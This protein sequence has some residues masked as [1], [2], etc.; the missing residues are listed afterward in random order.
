MTKRARLCRLFGL[1]AAACAALAL[2][3][4]LRAA[5]PG[6]GDPDAL[7]RDRE[8]L[9]LAA[10]A[11]KIWAA[12]LETNPADYDAACKLARAEHWIGERLARD[13]TRHFKAGMAAARQAIAAGPERADGYFWLGA[14]LG[15]HAGAGGILAALRYLKP[16]RQAFETS[17]RIDPRFNKGT[18]WCLLGKYYEAVP[19]LFGGSKTK[20]EAML[21]RCLAV[22]PDSILG[23]TTSRRPARPQEG[24]RSRLPPRSRRPSIRTSDRKPAC[25]SARRRD[26]CRSS[27][28]LLTAPRLQGVGPS[29]RAHRLSRDSCGLSHS[30]WRLPGPCPTGGTSWPPAPASH[31]RRSH[32]KGMLAPGYF[33]IRRVADLFDPASRRR[34][35]GGGAARPRCRG[36]GGAAHDRDVE[37]RGLRFPAPRRRRARRVRARPLSVDMMFQVS[38]ARPSAGPSRAP[39]RGPAPQAGQ[40]RPQRRGGPIDGAAAPVFWQAGEYAAVLEYCAADVMGTLAL[41]VACQQSRRLA[42]LSRSGRPNEIALRR[43]W[44]TVEQCLAL[45]LPDTSWMTQPLSRDSV[46]GWT[47]PS[48]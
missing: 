48:R 37:R 45:P 20:A 11:A 13:R 30:T 25:G 12:R 7:F 23:T 6:S 10:Q 1:T 14:N 33:S 4:A 31:A 16:T 36:G 32:P 34:D 18:A 35:T 21:R 9:G 39:R 43:G 29:E 24:R 44:L 22:D 17:V 38:R 47:A 15:S 27:K 41:A 19:G 8:D 28:A 26:C 2:L 42:W 40:V 5:A 46:V 3:S